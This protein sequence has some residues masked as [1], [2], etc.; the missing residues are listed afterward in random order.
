M[1]CPRCGGNMSNG[2][3]EDCGFSITAKMIG[4]NKGVGKTA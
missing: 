1:E 3:C 2:V 4:Y